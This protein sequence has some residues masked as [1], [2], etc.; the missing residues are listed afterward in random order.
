MG[1]AESAQR[2]PVG[3]P[4]EPEWKL[5]GEP[6]QEVP[7]QAVYACGC[8]MNMMI[9]G[10]CA[11]HLDGKPHMEVCASLMTSIGM[12]WRSSH[13]PAWLMYNKDAGGRLPQG[14]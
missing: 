14:R 6:V 13:P 2:S 9:A 12:N 3:A 11:N 8:K 10:P 5:P 4:Q 1:G 7:V